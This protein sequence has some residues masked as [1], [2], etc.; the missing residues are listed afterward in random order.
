MKNLEYKET[1]RITTNML[2]CNDSLKLSEILDI[3]QNIAGDHAEHLGIGFTPFI[4]K[5]WIWVVVRNRVEIVKDIKSIKEIEAETYA[6]NPRF[7]EFPREII[8]RSN[9]EEFAKIEQV[10][11]I[12]NINT[13][14]LVGPKELE[15]FHSSKPPLFASRTKKLPLIPKEQ[16]KFNS[17]FVVPY[18]MIDHNKHL[19]NTRYLDLYLNLYKNDNFVSFQAEYINQA[20]LDDELSLYTFKNDKQNYFYVYKDDT[21]IFYCL[22]N[23]K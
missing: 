1:F 8:L 12:L 13:K 15:E 19:N 18:S 21:L 6:I 10:W 2:D 11:M 16:L 17:K 22:V 9:G 7:I 23:T 14:Q 20:F 3:A 5:G 4:N